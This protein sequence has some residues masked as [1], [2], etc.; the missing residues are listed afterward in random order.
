MSSLF[1]TFFV[2]QVSVCNSVYLHAENS[3]NTTEWTLNK[4]LLWFQTIFIGMHRWW[5]KFFIWPRMRVQ[6]V[7]DGL[8]KNNDNNNHNNNNKLF[9]N[10]RNICVKRANFSNTGWF[11]C[12][13]FIAF[14]RNSRDNVRVCVW[15]H[16][17]INSK[18]YKRLPLTRG[19]SNL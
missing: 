13:R 10:Q 16:T 15:R 9:Y 4:Q 6:L 19:H 11:A 8:N 1:K 12:W 17:D 18:M 7:Y 2:W 14:I 3:L 5:C